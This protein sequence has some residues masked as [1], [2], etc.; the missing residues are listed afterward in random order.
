MTKTITLNDTLEMISDIK[1]PVP[2]RIAK[3]IIATATKDSVQNVGGFPIVDPLLVQDRL[4]AAKEKRSAAIRAFEADKEGLKTKLKTLGITEYL[5]IV[6]TAYWKNLCDRHHLQTV[7][8][9]M[10]GRVQVNTRVPYDL[11]EAAKLRWNAASAV[12]GAGAAL[13]TILAVIAFL[14][15][16]T[17]YF[18]FFMAMAVSSGL[19]SGGLGHV[20]TRRGKTAILRHLMNTPYEKLIAELLTPTRDYRWSTLA[21]NLILPVPP[22][23]VVL[24]LR[25]LRDARETFTVT[26]DPNAFQLMPSVETLYMKGHAIETWRKTQERL[27]PII[28]LSNNNATVVLAQFGEFK[29]ELDVIEDILSGTSIPLTQQSDRQ[30]Y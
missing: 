16:A 23:N 8:P 24:L 7:Q 2:E 22:M 3:E 26:A 1:Q 19:I 4:Y 5:A 27:D 20:G 17:D 12:M 14:N 6:P 21:A 28:T 29:W 30:Y 25:K 18:A 9:D 13:F 10:S 11:T 15:V